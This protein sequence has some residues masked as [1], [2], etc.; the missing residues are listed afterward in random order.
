MF[1]ED[2]SDEMM[3]RARRDRARKQ[4]RVR[5]RHL[6]V[7]C[8]ACGAKERARC[9]RRGKRGGLQRSD[10]S[11][12]ERAWKTH[13]CPAC[14]A[15]PG[16]WCEVAPGLVGTR[17]HV[18]QINYCKDINPSGRSMFGAALRCRVHPDS[19]RSDLLLGSVQ[20]AG[21]A[22]EGGCRYPVPPEHRP[23]RFERPLFE[24]GGFIT[25]RPKRGRIG[26]L[27]LTIRGG[28]NAVASQVEKLLAERRALNQA[29]ELN[30]ALRTLDNFAKRESLDAKINRAL[31]T[32]G[33]D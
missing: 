20:E 14:G 26:P 21:E 7:S 8:P 24:P 19:T 27:L 18:S 31:T 32:T 28:E 10:T 23:T 2:A 3:R 6:D 16:D 33:G 12:P 1:I 9:L 22:G 25:P 30:P 5:P 11:H 4:Q 13:E 15:L 17:A 29:M